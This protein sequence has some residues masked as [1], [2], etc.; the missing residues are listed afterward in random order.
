MDK[1]QIKLILQ[2]SRASGAD[3]DHPCIQEALRA[4]RQDPELAAWLDRERSFDRTMAGH[5]TGI[6]PPAELRDSILAGL[7]LGRRRTWWKVVLP[8]P[9]AACLIAAFFFFPGLHQSSSGTLSAAGVNF[10]EQYASLA[11]SQ[12]I[13]EAQPAFETRCPRATRAWLQD[14][15]VSVPEEMPVRMAR[16]GS[17]GCSSISGPAGKLAVIFLEGETAVQLVVAER[18]SVRNAPPAGSRTRLQ[19]NGMNVLGWATE[20]HVFWLMGGCCP[21]SLETYL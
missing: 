12:I 6:E 13:E 5:L 20:T 19:A 9:L 11:A 17:R 21:E 7:R 10:F 18:G 16:L 4:A 3:D 2:A 15:G 14:R 1:H 8:F